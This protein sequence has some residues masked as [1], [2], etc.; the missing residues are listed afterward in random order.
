VGQKEEYLSRLDDSELLELAKSVSKDQI[1][2]RMSRDNLIK[3]V[4][5]SLSL[6]EIKQKVNGNGN[7]ARIIAPRSKAFTL[8]GDGQ[9]F[10]VMYGIVSLIY[11][12]LPPIIYFPPSGVSGIPMTVIQEV[13]VFDFTEASLLM[14]FAVLNMIS[15]RA[16]RREFSGNKTGLISGSIALASS[17]LAMFYSVAT[18]LG[19]TYTVVVPP[20]GLEWVNYNQLG[21]F[22]QVFNAALMMLTLALIGVFFVV[23]CRQLPGG[24]ISLAAGFVYMFACFL[25]LFVSIQGLSYLLV[26]GY[27]YAYSNAFAA[28]PIVIA[29]I[30]GAGCFLAQKTA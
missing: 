13:A 11:V 5:A 4:K 8:G 1:H 24:N 21:T 6:E 9:L 3:I 22:L 19:L 15:M 25:Y 27:Y 2:S 29:G 23:H 10:L 7:P 30:L 26:Y 18:I 16:L 28:V 17:M 12:S 14:V 20:P